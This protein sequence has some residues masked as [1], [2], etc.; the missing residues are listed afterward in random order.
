M[1]VTATITKTLTFSIYSCWTTEGGM[2][3]EYYGTD[4]STMEEAL[5]LL[6]LANVASPG[7]KWFIRCDVEE[8]IK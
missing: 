1:K 6:E 8:N 5:R 7:S 3:D 2:D 4:V